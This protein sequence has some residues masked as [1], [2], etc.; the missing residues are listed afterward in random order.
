MR[1]NAKQ[2]AHINRRRQSYVFA[3]VFGLVNGVS[4]HAAVAASG[5]LGPLGAAAYTA[6]AK[7]GR[8]FNLDN[9]LA[10]LLLLGMIAVAV[11]LPAETAPAKRNA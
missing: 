4:L 8:L 6:V 2:P 1:R 10:L 5:E 3:M 9:G 11:L 7:V